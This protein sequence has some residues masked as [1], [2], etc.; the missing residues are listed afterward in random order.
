MITGLTKFSW[1]GAYEFE[2]QIS[3]WYLGGTV[4]KQM[5]PASAQQCMAFENQCLLISPSE[6]VD[7]SID[8]AKITCGERSPSGWVT[9]QSGVPFSMIGLAYYIHSKSISES[10]RS[11]DVEIGTRSL[12][13][14]AFPLNC[15]CDTFQCTYRSNERRLPFL[16]GVVKLRWS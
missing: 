8:R 1:P 9:V 2:S 3:K 16:H 12:T 6:V 7:Q 15:Y 13:L 11:F 14:D 5:V 10:L 4:R